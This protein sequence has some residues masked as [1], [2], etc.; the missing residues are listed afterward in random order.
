VWVG[1]YVPRTVREIELT[2]IEIENVL[3]H[4]LET[5]TVYEYPTPSI[6]SALTR[7]SIVSFLRGKGI[8]KDVELIAIDV[9][10]QLSEFSHTNVSYNWFVD[11]S[12]RLVET[13][14]EKKA[15][16]E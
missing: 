6:F 14:K 16:T 1:G 12:R 3:C 4:V 8:Q 10:R 2:S 7:L 15:E 9:F 11:W 13:I 5:I